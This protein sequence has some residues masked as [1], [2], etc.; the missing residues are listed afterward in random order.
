MSFR[1]TPCQRNHRGRLPRGVERRQ[2]DL[3]AAR[4]NPLQSS[5]AEKQRSGDQNGKRTLRS[6]LIF[7]YLI[8]GNQF[9]LSKGG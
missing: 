8:T 3:S 1:S 9:R 7:P 2:D 4:G 5:N 6:R